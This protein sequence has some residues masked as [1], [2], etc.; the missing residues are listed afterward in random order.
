MNNKAIYVLSKW[1]RFM[2]AT[3]DLKLSRQSSTIRLLVEG[4]HTSVKVPWPIVYWVIIYNFSVKTS[5]TLVQSAN[6]LVYINIA[7]EQCDI[8]SRWLPTVTTSAKCFLV[9]QILQ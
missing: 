6:S 4:R 8:I 9:N 1:P 3:V 2:Y 5:S 7:I